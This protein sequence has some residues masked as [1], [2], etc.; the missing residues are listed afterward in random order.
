MDEA[1]LKMRLKA[2]NH[3]G[4]RDTLAGME[5]QF[6]LLD[7]DGNGEL[8]LEE[9]CK[10]MSTGEFEMMTWDQAEVNQLLLLMCIYSSI[11]VVPLCVSSGSNRLHDRRFCLPPLMPMKAVL[12]TLRSLSKCTRRTWS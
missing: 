1:V 9:F 11:F 7:T 6:K 2:G 5:R 4:N 10:G 3:V 8:D 12:L